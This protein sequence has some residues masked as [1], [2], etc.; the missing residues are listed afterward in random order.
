M[1]TPFGTAATAGTAPTFVGPTPGLAAVVVEDPVAKA[2]VVI[3]AGAEAEL[4]PAG[5][6][7][8]AVDVVELD[9]GEAAASDS[10]ALTLRSVA[11]LLNCLGLHRDKFLSLSVGSRRWKS[12]EHFEHVHH[13]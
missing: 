9:P 10:A 13:H 4:P 7:C 8:V 11:K 12:F 2:G 3:L 1:A 6:P 5:V